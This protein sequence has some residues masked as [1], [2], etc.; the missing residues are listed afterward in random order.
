MNKEH[1]EFTTVKEDY[2]EYE[3]ENGQILKF[4]ISLADITVE[5]KE[6]GNKGSQLGLKEVSHVITDVEIDTSNMELSSAE[7][8][9]EE[10]QKEEL[11]FHSNKRVVNIYETQKHIIIMAP[12]VLKIFSTDKKDKTDS[13][14]LRFTYGV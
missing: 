12:S 4:K 8:V 5:V 2:N 9:T 10:D 1:V 6:D 3:V 13:P 11:K 7:Q 14:I